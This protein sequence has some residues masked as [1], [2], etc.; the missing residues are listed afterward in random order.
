MMIPITCVEKAS[1]EISLSAY[2]TLIP[3]LQSCVLDFYIGHPESSASLFPHVL[4]K[5]NNTVG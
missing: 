5:H 1:D 4:Q 3:V 2:S